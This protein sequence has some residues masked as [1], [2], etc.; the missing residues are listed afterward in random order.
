V[1]KPDPTQQ[2][3]TFIYKRESNLS[4]LGSTYTYYGDVWGDPSSDPLLMVHHAD[5]ADPFLAECC[6][7][8]WDDRKEQS[9][10]PFRF[11]TTNED[12]DP[13]YAFIQKSPFVQISVPDL[14]VQAKAVD[15]HEA[16]SEDENSDL[17]EDAGEYLGFEGGWV[18]KFILSTRKRESPV[19]MLEKTMWALQTKDEERENGNEGERMWGLKVKLEPIFRNARIQKYG[20]KERLAKYEIRATVLEVYVRPEF[21]NTVENSS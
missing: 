13:D 17:E 12:L 2:P 11:W 15:E 18:Q 4:V 1:Y 14:Q 7:E 9:S 20:G 5:N 16:P 10:P 8:D 6:D 21:V 19:P 3:Y